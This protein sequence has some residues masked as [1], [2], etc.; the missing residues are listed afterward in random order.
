MK[1]RQ[2]LLDT[3]SE[4]FLHYV[5]S[6][7]KVETTRKTVK[8]NANRHDVARDS[9]ES[10]YS[11]KAHFKLPFS[12]SYVHFYSLFFH[13]LVPSWFVRRPPPHWGSATNLES[14]CQCLSYILLF[15]CTLSFRSRILTPFLIFSFLSPSTVQNYFTRR[16]LFICFFFLVVAQVSVSFI[17]G[18]IRLQL[19][20]YTNH[21]T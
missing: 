17:A 10:E 5:L 7:K 11:T 14:L 13:Y 2:S 8:T 20:L 19:S 15:S 6:A 4:C 21:K 12:I 18:L 16:R 9:G 1:N 3:A